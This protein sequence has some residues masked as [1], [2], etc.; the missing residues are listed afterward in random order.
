MTI[1]APQFV[2]LL[3]VGKM[4]ASDGLVNTYLLKWGGLQQLIYYDERASS[5]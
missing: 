4:F 5:A 1:A 3:Y 2:S